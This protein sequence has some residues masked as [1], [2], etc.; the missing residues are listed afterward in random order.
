[1]FLLLPLKFRSCFALQSVLNSVRTGF[2][3]LETSQKQV[4]GKISWVFM[5]GSLSQVIFSLYSILFDKLLWMTLPS[6]LFSASQF[7][8]EIAICC[9]KNVTFN[10]VGFSAALAV[11][12][13]IHS[14]LQ[15]LIRPEL[16]SIWKTEKHLV[17]I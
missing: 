16:I 17:Q 14:C 5:L 7:A 2:V 3:F 12:L 4:F 6:H 1:M 9:R 8:T 15:F 11:P 13:L 10:A